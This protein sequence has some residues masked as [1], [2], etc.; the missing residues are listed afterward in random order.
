ME[1][2]RLH[3]V[4]DKPVP[5]MV[6]RIIVMFLGMLL[7]AFGIALSRQTLLGSSPISSVPTVLSFAT[8]RTIGT[9][10]WW[11]NLFF[12]AMQA[13]LL[14]KE[15]HPI[16]L[17]QIPYLLL[18]S[19]AID[20]FV[21]L[22]T[23]WPFGSYALCLMWIVV[24]GFAVALGVYLQAQMRLIVTPGDAVVAAIAHASGWKFSRVKLGFDV[25]QMVLAV[26]ISLVTMGTLMGI[27]E[28]TVISAILIGPMIGWIGKAVGD[29]HRFIPVE[30][31]PTFIPE[32]K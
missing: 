28:G 10:T 14:R 7:V 30:G 13:V 11:L 2:T 21:Q 16:Q 27:R 9:Y 26:I 20:L 15:F 19:V 5:N 23:P 17:L 31:Y 1:E 4:L 25:T 18:F 22:V 12:I 32:F 8:D 24:S 29:M 3:N 6:V